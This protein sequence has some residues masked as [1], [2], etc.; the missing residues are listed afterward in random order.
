MARAVGVETTV[1]AETRSMSLGFGT[2]VGAADWVDRTIRRGVW[3]G[4][5]V[6]SVTGAAIVAAGGSVGRF[7]LIVWISLCSCGTF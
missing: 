6:G 5:T 2:S 3:V 4:T 7:F 1:S